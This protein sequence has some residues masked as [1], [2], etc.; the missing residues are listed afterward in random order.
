MALLPKKNQQQ[1]RAF[2]EEIDA[3]LQKPL[4]MGPNP[5]TATQRKLLEDEE[6]RQTARL[7]YIRYLRNVR[8]MYREW[9]GYTE[10]FSPEEHRGDYEGPLAETP[11]Q[12]S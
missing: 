12:L 2:L 10:T 5:L 3:I 8:G 6:Q 9:P 1:F 11:L 7:A 4:D